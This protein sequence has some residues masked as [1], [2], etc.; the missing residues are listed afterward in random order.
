MLL[1][2]NPTAW[3]CVI[4]A[5]VLI[6]HD[7]VTVQSLNPQTLCTKIAYWPVAFVSFILAEH[8]QRATT[9]HWCQAQ[10]LGKSP[11]SGCTSQGRRLIFHCNLVISSCT[12]NGLWQCWRSVWGKSSCDR[13]TTIRQHL[14]LAFNHLEANIIII[15]L[16]ASTKRGLWCNT[17]SR[18]VILLMPHKTLRE[19][20]GGLFRPEMAT[21][22]RDHLYFHLN[23]FAPLTTRYSITLSQSECLLAD[24]TQCQN[25]TTE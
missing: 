16:H 20:H 24:Y 2:G 11:T 13:T 18:L 19:R 12:G 25:L 5:G 1:C 21:V 9:T 8:V 6:R 14:T 4:C 10:T 7:S 17:V 23:M 22:D 3:H 15:A